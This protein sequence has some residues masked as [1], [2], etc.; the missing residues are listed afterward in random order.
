VAFEAP[1]VTQSARILFSCTMWTDYDCRKRRC[2]LSLGRLFLRVLLVSNMAIA[3]SPDAVKYAPRPI[4]LL[5]GENNVEAVMP[6]MFIANGQQHLEFIPASQIKE[7]ME[8]GGQPVRLGD[9][10]SVLGE[11]TETINRLQGENDK[12]WEV[13]MKDAPQQEPPTV[14]VQHCRPAEA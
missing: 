2:E 8:K 4:L 9:V 5:R 13:A 7:S 14:F 10:L 12:L 1:S 11:A 6:M 3:Q